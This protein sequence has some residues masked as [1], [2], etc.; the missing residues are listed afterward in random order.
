MEAFVDLCKSREELTGEAAVRRSKIVEHIAFRNPACDG[1]PTYFVAEK[2]GRLVAHLGRMPTRFA[3]GGQIEAASYFHDLY[4]HPDAR[5]SG[6]QGFFLSMQLYDAAETASPGFAAM[7]WTNEINIALQESRKYHQMWTKRYVKILGLEPRLSKLPLG[8]LTKSVNGLARAAIAGID[9]ARSPGRNPAYSIHRCDSFQHDYD[10]LAN[11]VRD[12]LGIAPIKDSAYLN[13]KYTSR[14]WL[15][16]TAFEARDGDGRLMGYAVIV[17]P[18]PIHKVAVLAELVAI[19]NNI[20]V[21]ECLLDASIEHARE[22]NADRVSAVA[23]N[24]SYLAVL[25]SRL[26][27]PRGGAEPLFLANR[28]KS[29]HADAISSIENWHM[30]MGDSEG[31]F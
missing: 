29:I 15:S 2:D 27:I 8:P 22:V 3:V 20:A 31:P 6:A 1:H 9:R 4:V 10:Q 23:T 18:D 30:Q 25:R 19:E 17:D 12:T 24:G 28:K 5:K 11:A 21:A 7:V 16:S 26:F 14:P 13:W